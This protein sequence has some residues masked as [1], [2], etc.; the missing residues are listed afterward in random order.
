MKVIT[1]K[2]PKKLELINPV[3]G[4]WAVRWNIEELDTNARCDQKLFMHKPSLYEIQTTLETSYNNECRGRIENDL[5]WNDHNVFLNEENQR[6][7]A[8]ICPSF[9]ED[10]SMLPVTLKFGTFDTNDYYTFTSV[11]ELK[12]FK[13]AVAKH[14]SDCLEDCWT[15]KLNINLEEYK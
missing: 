6:N 11:D 7:I 14:I 13:A 2:N 8:L 10:K 5:V 3:N 9:I 15:K 12:K 4:V 1:N